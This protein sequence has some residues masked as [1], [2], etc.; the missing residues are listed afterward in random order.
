MGAVG[1]A[2]QHVVM[3]KEADTPVRLLFFL[4]PTV[5]GNGRE[6]DSAA[7]EQAQRQSRKRESLAEMILLFAQVDIGRHDGL[8]TSV[9]DDREIGL[10]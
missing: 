6:A 10:E 1:K 2:G 4:G 5:P 9:D 7:N 3:S 8:W